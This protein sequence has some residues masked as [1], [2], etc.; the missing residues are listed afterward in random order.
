MNVIGIDIGGTK[1]CGVVYNPSRFRGAEADGKKVVDEL[2]IVTPKNLYEFERNLIKLADF[3]AAKGKVLGVGIGM[4]GLIDDKRG[5]AVYS[6]NIKFIKNLNVVKLFQLNGYKNVKIDNDANCFTR[7]E[8][9]LGQGKKLQN[10]LALTLGTGIGGGIVINRKIYRGQ[11]NSGAELGHMVSAGL[12][13]E[14]SFARARDNRSNKDL[15]SVLGQAFAG[16]INIFAPQAI[17]LGGGVATDKSRHFL[18]LAIK[19]MKKFQFSR[20]LKPKILISKLKNA[21]ALGAAL[22]VK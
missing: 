6:P 11:N 20:Q 3:L 16:L 2:T 13:L 12:F 21:G 9:L 17:I 18:P 7:A 8:M 15:G 14:K 22:L 5:T 1:I 4:A 10:F 19:E